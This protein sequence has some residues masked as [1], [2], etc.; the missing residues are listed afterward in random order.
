MR[1]LIFTLLFS[2]GMLLATT[3]DSLKTKKWAVGLSYSPD[4]CFRTP[5]AKA[6]EKGSSNMTEKG[7]MGFT[8]GI[9]LRY[10]LLEKI[11]V[12]FGALYSTKGQKTLAG[13]F[14][15]L[16]PT[17]GYVTEPEKTIT[18]TYQYLEIPLKVNV[19]LINTKLKIFPSIGC[20]V[21]IFMGKKTTVTSEGSK[22]TSTA[23]EQQN[24]PK[25]ELAVLAGVGISYD[26]S[27]KLFVKIEPSFRSFIRP[28]VDFPVSGTF[29]SVGANTGIYLK[30]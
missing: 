24:I 23:F 3:P 14:S 25:T 30:F 10:Q 8:T 17:E 29:Y 15:W 16:T 5:Y 21:N 20:S 9:N 7:K 12:E 26:I 22:E 6:S 19:Y 11:G 1:L 4:F 13:S 18:Y 2:S 27:D 28:L